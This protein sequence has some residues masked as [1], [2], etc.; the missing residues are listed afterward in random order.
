MNS[1]GL[2]KTKQT[3]SSNFF[4]KNLILFPINVFK[5]SDLNYTQKTLLSL[6]FLYQNSEKLIDIDTI[7]FKW[8]NYGGY[9]LQRKLLNHLKELENKEYIHILYQFN[10]PIR[11]ML[12]SHPVFLSRHV[13][14]KKS[15]IYDKQICFEEILLYLYYMSQSINWCNHST[16]IALDLGIHRSTVQKYSADLVKKGL[17]YKKEKFSILPENARHFITR[18]NFVHKPV[19]SN[20]RKPTLLKYNNI[21]FKDKLFFKKKQTRE[22]FLKKLS[23]A[24]EFRKIHN[25]TFMQED[26]ISLRAFLEDNTLLERVQKTVKIEKDQTYDLNFI[27]WLAKKIRL[28]AYGEIM[29]YTEKLIHSLKKEFRTGE[30]TWRWDVD[31]DDIHYINRKAPLAGARKKKHEKNTSMNL[32]FY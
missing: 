5:A 28:R 9:K 10:K 26:T 6:C 16:K 22:G 18:N 7:A 2:Y 31:Y 12:T 24:K 30:E 19:N 15:L 23:R 14:L 20:V 3:T 1:S 29:Y 25:I 27:R 13:G 21:I 4:N 11:L 32:H 8:N 17:L